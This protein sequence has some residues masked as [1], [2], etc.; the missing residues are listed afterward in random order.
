MTKLATVADFNHFLDTEFGEADPRMN[1]LLEL[2]SAKVARYCRQSFVVVTNDL[3]RLSVNP[4]ART[5]YL[6]ERPV[7][8]V[9]SVS[10]IGIGVTSLPVTSYEWNPQGELNWL[11]G[12]QWPHTVEVQYDHGG[13]VPDDVVEKVCMVMARV[14][15]N[16]TQ[17]VQEAVDAH[18]TSH[19]EGI[20]LTKSDKADL[21]DYRQPVRTTWIAPSVTYRHSALGVIGNA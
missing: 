2:A 16:P 19:G 1:R 17:D 6:P 9:D 21:A 14:M 13:P 3:V 18:A 10:L 7:T 5:I 8:G 11:G 4:G 12:G 20:R 15:D